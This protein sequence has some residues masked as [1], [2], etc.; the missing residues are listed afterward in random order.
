[1]LAHY[2]ALTDPEG[3]LK[4]LTENPPFFRNESHA[5]HLFSEWGARGFEKALEAAHARPAF[6]PMR[7]RVLRGVVRAQ[8]PKNPQESPRIPNKPSLRFQTSMRTPAVQA[9]SMTRPSLNST[10]VY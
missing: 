9:C 10:Y 2:W 8:I 1:M 5:Y 7:S 6:N 3:F 4:F